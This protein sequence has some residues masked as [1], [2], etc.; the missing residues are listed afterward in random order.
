MSVEM[1]GW[2]LKVRLRRSVR[3]EQDKLR[4]VSGLCPGDDLH[5]LEEA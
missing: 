2:V 1:R 5:P 3:D 4:E